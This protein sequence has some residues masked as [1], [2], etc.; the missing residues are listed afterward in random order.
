MSITQFAIK[1]DRFTIF[2]VLILA[3][4]GILAYFSLPKAQDPG[5]TIRTAVVTTYLPGASPNRVEQ[6]VTD[7]IEQEIQQMPELDFIASE[8]QTGISVVYVNFKQSYSEMQPIFDNLRRKVERVAPDLPEGV[9]GPI[10]NDEFGDVFGVIYALTGDG[11]SFAELKDVADDARNRLLLLDNVAKVE[12]LGDQQEAIYVEYSNARLRELGVSPQQLR[13]ALQSMNILS[14]GGDVRIG[15][16]RITLEPT[17]NFESLDEI[18]RA[19]IAIPGTSEVVQLEDIAEVSRAY[20]EPRPSVVHA[21]GK[22]ALAIA[23]SMK[24]GGNILELGQT[25]DRVMPEIQAQHPHGIDFDTLAYQPDLVATSV[26]GFTANML[27]AIAIVLLV[28]LISLGLR[29]GLIVAALVPA[30]M[31]I[32]FLEM[33]WFGVGI[34]KMSL[35]ALIIALGLLVDNAIVMAE[36]IMVRRQRGEDK[37]TAAVNTGKE[38]QIPLLTSSLTTAA[39][40]LTIFLAE[41]AVGEF[42]GSIFVV[43]TLALLTSWLLAMTLI[44]LLSVLFMKIK[45]AP[46]D[47]DHQKFT[48]IVF[49]FY[50]GILSFSLK[51]RLA[52]LGLM[53]LLFI[54]AIKGLGLVPKAFIPP[55]TDPVLNAKFDMPIG[56]AIESTEEIANEIEQFIHQNWLL[57]EAE[58]TGGK[59]GVVN[60]ITFIGQGAPRFVLGYDP[61]T[62]SPRHIAMIANTTDHRMIPDLVESIEQFVADR[63]PDLTTQMKKLENGPPVDYPIAIR[64]LGTDEN[65]LFRL[66]VGL[67]DHLLTIPQ[68]AAVHDD[69]GPQVKKFL[70]SVDQ[71]RAR[72]AG[73]TSEDVAVSL[74]ASLSGFVMTN[75]RENTDLIPITVRSVAADRQDLAKLE[76]ITIYS[77]VGGDQV[78][79][80]Q[81]AEV[82][83]AWQP[84]NIKR[85]DRRRALTVNVQLTPGVTATEVNTILLPWLEEEATTW[86][87]GYA[88]EEGGEKEASGDAASSIIAKLPIAGLL[89]VLLLVGQFNSL[90]RPLIILLTIPLGMVGVSV[91][92]IAAKTVFGFFT[93]LGVVSLAGI[94]I[95][96]AIVLIDR[97]DMEIDENGA[98]PQDAVFLSCQERL[99]PILLTTATTIGGMLPLW[100]S[101][102][103]MFETMAVTIIFGLAFAT[104][105]T[106]VFV[107][108]MYSLLFRVSFR[109]F[110]YQPSTSPSASDPTQVQ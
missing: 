6:L 83:A 34:D 81:V 42:T 108:V 100:L 11:F 15:R 10:V 55:A 63:Y 67:R 22:P 40:F 13:S 52:F 106:L 93:I 69:W 3:L 77:S 14:S 12:I 25:L 44:P 39:A 48:G 65:T 47:G 62:P 64:L 28:M 18:K 37:V 46:E 101:Q 98:L 80:R 29:T 90:R 60:W 8:S 66:A 58:I 19:V 53:V 104:V 72:R 59:D 32:A 68:V 76:G 49:R 84:G 50:R 26:N 5:F 61:G 105:L 33:Q 31:A 71:D 45:E 7:K 38:L 78:P 9:K 41:S 109:K 75:F 86:P 87:A 110:K 91:G 96:N 97:I 85:R 2:L 17:G 20:E 79:L 99:R 23:V 82:K 30:V 24:D 16:E 73:V 102:D 103:P 54:L 1:N 56:T 35:A 36:G 4:F 89:I 21:N 27:Q 94:I 43:V 51:R 88:Y 70:V 107:P 92:L 95:N 74:K 57:T